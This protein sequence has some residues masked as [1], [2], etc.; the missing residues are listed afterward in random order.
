MEL[1]ARKA[2]LFAQVIDGGGASTP[3]SAPTTSGVVRG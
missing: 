2:A 3:G 1:K